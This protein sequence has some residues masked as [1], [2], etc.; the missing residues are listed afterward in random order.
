VGGGVVPL[1]RCTIR[2]SKRAQVGQPACRR[3][4]PTVEGPLEHVGGGVRLTGSVYP[5]W[6]PL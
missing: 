1:I 3:W 4:W 5:T 2:R 6:Y